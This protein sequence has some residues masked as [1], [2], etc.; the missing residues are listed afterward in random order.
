VESK[1]AAELSKAA[2]TTHIHQMRKVHWFEKFNWF[3]TSEG[4]LVLSGR[5]PQQ[6]EMLLKRCVASTDEA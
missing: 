6:T 5:D 3:V 1:T 4:Y 2:T